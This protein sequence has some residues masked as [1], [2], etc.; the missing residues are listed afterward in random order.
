MMYA[1][2]QAAVKAAKPKA[3]AYKLT[4]G[5][6]LYL[7]VKPTGAKLWRYKFRVCGKEQTYA[8]GCYPDVG[9][10][11]AREEHAGARHLVEQGISP[12]LDRKAKRQEQFSAACN[13]FEAVARRWMVERLPHISASHARRVE[14]A[15][16]RDVFPRVGKLGIRDVTAAHLRPILQSVAGKVTQSDAKWGRSRGA[17]TVAIQIRQWCS[18]IFR[19][20]VVHGLTDYDPAP[21]LRDLIIRPK[22]QHHRHLIAGEIPAL[23]RRLRSFT[24]TEQVKIAIELLVL[25]F[26]RTGELRKGEWSE[27]D[28]QH[29]VWRIPASRMKMRREHMVPLSTRA[30]QLFEQL[31][32]ITGNSRYMFPNQRTPGAVM[33]AMTVNRALER[34]GY[35][36]RLSGHGCR[37]TASTFLNETG[38]PAHIIEKQLAHERKNS[39]EAAYNHAQYMPERA[40]M[41]QFW[42]DFLMSDENK[43]VPIKKVVDAVS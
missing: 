28:L 3:S 30:V 27:L 15:L 25:T 20:A 42:C 22:V 10:A 39:V 37:G 14:A 19:Y 32:L 9:L 38:Y 13:T 2:T 26:V 36:G 41:M 1:L 43:V 7:L 8:I 11:R 24:G 16:E 40:K 23:A 21:A 5:G 6:G 17:T 35:G 4:D 18:G 34:M 31:R 29:S 12:V 33:S